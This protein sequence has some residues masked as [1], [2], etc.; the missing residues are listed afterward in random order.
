M[1]LTK[2]FGVHAVKSILDYSPDKI[3][4]AWVGQNRQDQRF[5]K[6][7]DSLVEQG[8]RLE[9]VDRKTLDKLTEGKNHQGIVVEI[10]MPTAKTEQ[11]LKQKV[12]DLTEP[13]FFLVMDH[14]QDPHNLGACLRTTDAVGVTGVIITKDQAAGI[15]GT[16]C[17]VA[18]G[19]AETVSVY[20]VTNLVRILSWLKAQG[21][22]VI[23]AA[24]E[25][26]QTIYQTDFV[27]SIA[28]VVGAEDKGLRRLTR[29][30]CDMLVKIP[31]SGKIESLNVSVAAGILLYE[32][33]RQRN[34]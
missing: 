24:G 15:T 18:S 17:R 31:M 9:K 12:M 30:N 26:E 6:L 32:A 5:Q 19:A 28:L 14:I 8:V 29:E 4:Q 3:Y 7:I 33:F 11:E 22:W 20:Q 13:A 2:I 23:G 34:V 10:E 27:G 16:V 21:I 25:A 1:K